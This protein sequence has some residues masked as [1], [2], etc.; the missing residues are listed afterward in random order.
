MAATEVVRSFLK[1]LSLLE[2][3]VAG[4]AFLAI[5]LLLFADVMSRELL[6]NG[7][8]GAQ[9]VA[10][11]CMAVAAFV[12]F[13]LTTH[14]DGHFR[15]EGLERLLPRRFDRPLS[16][17]ANIVSCG[18]CLFLA[19]W[20]LRF[21]IVSFENDERG[22]ALG[23]VVWPIQTAMVW[24]FASSG[25]RYAVFARWPDLKPKASELGP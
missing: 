25:V 15:I 17:L 2:Y 24:M 22:V 7:I 21:V 4:A 5:T 14:L 9:R 19:Y 11:Y 16:R 18:I 20:A 3:V 23:F 12:G 10:V 1:A 8:Y 13:A 6:G